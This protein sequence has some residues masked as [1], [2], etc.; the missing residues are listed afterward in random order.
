MKESP[1][2]SLRKSPDSQK[3]ASIEWA[4]Q[5]RFLFSSQENSQEFHRAMDSKDKRGLPYKTLKS[6]L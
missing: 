3:E 2:N 1:F 5:Q 4:Y 6:P